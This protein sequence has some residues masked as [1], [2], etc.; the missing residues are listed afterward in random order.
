MV[1]LFK[2]S[3]QKQTTP[4]KYNTSLHLKKLTLE[5]YAHVIHAFHKG[6]TELNHFLKESLLEDYISFST[7]DRIS[8]DLKLVKFRTCKIPNIPSIKTLFYSKAV[9]L[10]PSEL[11]VNFTADR[12]P[13]KTPEGILSGSPP[14]KVTPKPPPQAPPS[15]TKERSVSPPPLPSGSPNMPKISFSQ[16]E[17]KPLLGSTAPQRESD[18]ATGIAILRKQMSDELKKIRTNLPNK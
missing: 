3:G 11:D 13:S 14:L 6:L 1:R 18:R 8:K 5:E 15:L 7:F 4:F 16:T 12:T 10:K 9:E 2:K 17:T